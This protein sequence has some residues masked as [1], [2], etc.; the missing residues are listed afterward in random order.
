MGQFSLFPE[1]KTTGKSPLL[2]PPVNM[3]RRA[4]SKAIHLLHAL[5]R[6]DPKASRQFRKVLFADAGAPLTKAERDRFANHFRSSIWQ[7]QSLEFFW[8]PSERHI[9]SRA[10]YAA[11]LPRRRLPDES[12]YIG[13]YEVPVHESDFLDDLDDLILKIRA[14]VAINV[15]EA[16]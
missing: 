13:S 2:T 11:K 6:S 15:P 12:I 10:T 3:V 16:E 8:L 7:R 14:G 9:T 4:I 1:D 5:D